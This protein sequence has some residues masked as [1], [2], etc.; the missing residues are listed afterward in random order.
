M[1]AAVRGYIREKFDIWH[2]II[3]IRLYTVENTMPMQRVFNWFLN[4]LIVLPCL[5]F[6][7]TDFLKSKIKWTINQPK[8]LLHNER[9]ELDKFKRHMFEKGFKWI[10]R[11][12]KTLFFYLLRCTFF[13][14]WHSIWRCLLPLH[15]EFGSPEHCFT[16]E[17]KK[18]TVKKKWLPWIS[19]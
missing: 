6:K 17:I 12:L 11:C 9:R 8:Q 7:A 2:I 1:Y 15:L 16:V 18:V 10:A 4:S 19:Y 13:D 5:Y 3:S 14:I